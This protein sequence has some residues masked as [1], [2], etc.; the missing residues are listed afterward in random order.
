MDGGKEICCSPLIPLRVFHDGDLVHV[1]EE[2]GVWKVD[3]RGVGWFGRVVGRGGETCLV[4]NRI[5]SAKGS[6][7]RVDSHSI[8]GTLPSLWPLK[9]KVSAFFF[10]EANLFLSA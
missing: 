7:T 8:L 1:F 3:G 2:T 10:I 9:L 6:P 5:L 4:R